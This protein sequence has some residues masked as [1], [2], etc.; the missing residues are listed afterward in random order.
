MPPP[1]GAVGLELSGFIEAPQSIGER[2]LQRVDPD[3][4]DLN[5]PFANV[6]GRRRGHAASH[7]LD[8]V[9]ELSDRTLKVGHPRFYERP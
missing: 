5:Q 8:S 3:F 2:R 6:G 1:R 7:P 4:S 9:L